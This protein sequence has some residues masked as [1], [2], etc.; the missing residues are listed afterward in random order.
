MI[1]CVYT[2]NILNSSGLV[3][4]IKNAV[5]KKENLLKNKYLKCLKKNL[6]ENWKKFLAK[7]KKT[8][9]FSW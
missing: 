9:Y 7:T 3:Y 1:R 5:I 8:S 4:L 2:I 6:A